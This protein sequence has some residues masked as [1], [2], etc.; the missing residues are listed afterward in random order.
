M[1]NHQLHQRVN[2]ILS[3]YNIDIAGTDN[4]FYIR[5]IAS[6]DTIQELYQ[7]IYGSHAAAAHVFEQL[8]LN[9]IKAYS[10]RPAAFKT[11]DEAKAATDNWFL[12]NQITGMSLYVDRFCGSLKNLGNKL[13]Y[14]E[15]LGVNFLHLMPLF[16]S[17]PAA[18]DGGY[19]V[20]DFRKIDK[21][22][23]SLADLKRLRKQMDARLGLQ[24]IPRL[25]I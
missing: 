1:Y 18:S 25:M 16:E 4:A 13:T 3:Q 12:S 23:G 10:T 20:S 14:F 7:E 19:A 8:F 22:F 21:R 9:I 15:K 5:L 11:K 6:A 17:P 24:F 2:S